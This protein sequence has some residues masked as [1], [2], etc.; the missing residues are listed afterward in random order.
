MLR[1]RLN[2][3]RPGGGGRGRRQIP[4]CADAEFGAVTVRWAVRE[5]RPRDRDPAVPGPDGCRA[6]GAARARR[7]ALR[8]R[9]VRSPGG[10]AITAVAAARLGLRT[11]AV[12][13][14]GDDI[15]GEFVREQL[16]SEG[17]NVAGPRTART[18]Q[19][20]VMPFG[21]DRA[22]VTI[23]PGARARVRP[24]SLALEPRRGRREPRA[25]RPRA[26]RARAATS[27]AATTTRARSR[28]GCRRRSSRTR[29]FFLDRS[30]R[31]R[32]DAARTR[33]RTPSRCSPKSV[34]TVVGW[35]A[36]T[37]C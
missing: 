24:T 2:Q 4:A 29:A 34:E 32:A 31:A 18:P 36:P 5:R 28:A 9:P 17:V 11:A 6:R 13:P 26:R 25:D 33:S 14:L 23:D 12:A 19:T 35:T 37:A 10:G 21:D 3:L 7:G 27:R 8:R 22:M 20:L 30:R 16:E 1:A 15:A